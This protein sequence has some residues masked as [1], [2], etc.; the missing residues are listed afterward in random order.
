MTIMET[1]NDQIEL[2]NKNGR[3]IISVTNETGGIQIVGL[4][5]IEKLRIFLNDLK[6]A[7]YNMRDPFLNKKI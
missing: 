1:T 7:N 5:N 2:L 4:D 3:K 6:E